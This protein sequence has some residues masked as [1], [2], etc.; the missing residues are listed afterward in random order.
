[1]GTRGIRTT[2]QR[3]ANSNRTTVNINF[4]EWNTNLL[5]AEDGLTSKGFI[6]FIE[7][8]IVFGQTGLFENLGDSIC[9]ADTHNSWRDTDDGCGNEFANNRKTE[10]FRD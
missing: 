3:M 5:D 7:I 6:D 9:G 4:L 10:T 8:D 1:M 2:T